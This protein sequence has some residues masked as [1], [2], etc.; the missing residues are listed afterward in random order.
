MCKRFDVVGITDSP[1][2]QFSDEVKNLVDSGKV[3]SG[4]KRHHEIMRPYLPTHHIWIDVTV[5]LENTFAQYRSHDRI[6]VLASGDPLFFGYATTLRRN[7]PDA[8]IEVYPAFNSLQQLAHRL[9]INYEDMVC[10]SLTGRPWDKF[11]ERIIRGERL[12]GVLTDKR[13]TPGVIASQLLKY[14]YDGYEICIGAHLGNPEEESVCTLSLRVAAESVFPFP[15]CVIL[16]S[17]GKSSHIRHFGIPD[18]CFDHLPGREKMITKMPIRLLSLSMLDLY[19][20]RNLWDIGF[21]TGSIS[22]EARL[23]FPHL[24][25]TAFEKREECAGIMERNA[26][27]LGAPGIDAVIGDFFDTDLNVF[28]VPDAV[29]IGGH[30][31]R[32]REMLNLINRHASPDCAIVFNS[33]SDASREEFISRISEIGKTI[34]E[35]HTITLD[36]F[37]T[38]TI[39]K[40]Q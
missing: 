20:R 21:C 5:P 8:K 36:D 28:P 33:V 27:R 10:V 40:A 22:I 38:I 16:K 19:E 24:K 15:N 30:G 39:L 32:L 1:S 6:V 17:S 35:S 23:Q 11:W 9:K 34:V 29:F 13:N 12:V 2:P 7:F 31:G 18:K 4:G 14:G 37:N 3:F 25:I 26:T